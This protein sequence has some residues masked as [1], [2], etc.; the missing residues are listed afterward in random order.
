MNFAISMQSKRPDWKHWTRLGSVSLRESIFLSLNVCPIWYENTIINYR[1]KHDSE[2]YRPKLKKSEIGLIVKVYKCIEPE[3][4]TRLQVAKS[5]AYKQDWVL[6]KG[7]FTPEEINEDM[8]VDLKKFFFA[9]FTQMRFENEY[10]EIPAD[11][12]MTVGGEDNPN[13]EVLASIPPS[14]EK[15]EVKPESQL[16][17]FSNYRMAL[18]QTV[19]ELLNINPNKKPTAMLVKKEWQ[20]NKP[21]DI[22]NVL[23]DGFLYINND[24]EAKQTS[25][26]VLNKAIDNLLMPKKSQ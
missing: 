8:L 6:D 10:D 21:S 13:L 23:P 16:K 2:D 17:R 25:W 5:W 3:F 7:Y 18:L 12:N 26:S 1:Q 20:K 19:K 9:A 11:L 22:V 4:S 14:Q 15:W 24:G